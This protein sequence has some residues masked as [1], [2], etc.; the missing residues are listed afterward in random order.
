METLLIYIDAEF[1]TKS[2]QK[3]KKIEKNKFLKIS[4]FAI[5]HLF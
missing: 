2:A 4:Q 1:L 3:L 5:F